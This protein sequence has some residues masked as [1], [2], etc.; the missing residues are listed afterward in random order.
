MSFLIKVCGLNSPQAVGA[1]LEAGADMA[2]F[3][4][5]KQS[6][7]NISLDEARMLSAQMGH[8]ARKVALTVDADD[9]TLAAVV[10]ALEPDVLQLHGSETPDRVVDVR[11]RFGL[12]VMRAIA[13][14]GRSDLEQI[15]AFDLAADYLLFDA[16]PPAGAARPGG[17][18]ATFD[19]RLLRGL[20]QK[21]PWLLAGGLDIDNVERA[22]RATGTKGVD[23]SSGVESARGVK[24]AEK[25][26]EFVARARRAAALGTA[27]AIV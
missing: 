23:V 1:A 8:R 17:H 2:G 27:A 22:I 11:K 14:A 18:G 12:P 24:D 5:F 15:D 20:T 25:I 21:R 16:R 9:A 19:W 13:I 6:P 26:A 10:E 7:R 3:V 4:F